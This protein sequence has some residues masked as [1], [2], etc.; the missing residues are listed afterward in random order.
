MANAT[1]RPWIV[2]GVMSEHAHDICL[3]YDVP[4]AG[5]PIVIAST[6]PDEYVPISDV[7]AEANARLICRAV[8]AY[9]DLIAAC[10][11][12]KAILS[13]HIPPDAFDGHAARALIMVRDAIVKARGEQS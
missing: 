13:T 9:D 3:G 7:E 11:A 10:E 5:S 2:D 12:A 6:N 1:P 4:R 8:N